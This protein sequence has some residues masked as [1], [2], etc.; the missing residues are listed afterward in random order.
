MTASVRSN[1]RLTRRRK[2]HAARNNKKDGGKIQFRSHIIS[3]GKT[4]IAEHEWQFEAFLPL[5]KKIATRFFWSSYSL[6]ELYSIAADGLDLA[7]EPYDPVAHNN[8]L[9]AYAIPWI[10]GALKRFITS[11]HSI[12]IG[13]RRERGK[14][15][16]RHS[17]VDHFG[18]VA[19]GDGNV[20]LDVF[21]EFIEG[22][23]D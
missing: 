15:L 12:V 13:E 10:Q 17:R 19:I 1:R 16:P 20:R 8:G 2:G 3:K 5:A 4:K 22:E 9:A 6:E 21:D 14:H 11:G 7:I 18:N 23:S